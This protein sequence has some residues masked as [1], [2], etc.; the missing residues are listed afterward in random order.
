MRD[1]KTSIRI[2][3]E[4]RERLKKRKVHPKQ[5]YYEVIEELLENEEDK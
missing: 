4:L 3:I 2:P 5:P 1:D